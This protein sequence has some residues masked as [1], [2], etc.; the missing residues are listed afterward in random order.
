MRKIKLFYSY[1]HKDELHRDTL[2]TH[3]AVLRDQGKI[4]EWYD[5][6]ITG[7]A[8]VDEEIE[9]NMQ[10]SHIILLL[11]SP[12]FISS[13]SCRNELYRA[14][15]LKE[16]KGVE[17]VPIILRACS[18]KETEIKNLLALPRDGKP[19]TKWENGDEAWEDVC[20]QL[21]VVIE[22]VTQGITPKIKNEFKKD[23]LANP[24]TNSSLCELFVYPD[25][26]ENNVNAK[27]ENNE[28]NSEKLKCLDTF[29]HQYI[30]L[31]GKE[32]SGKTSL[33]NMLFL[34]Y[35]E[36]GFYPILINGKKISGNG[37]VLKIVNNECIQQYNNTKDYFDVVKEKR[38][39]LIDDINDQSMNKVNFTKFI[40]SI[41]DYFNTAIVFIDELSHLSDKSLKNN[42]FPYFNHYS[43]RRLGHKK[44]DELIKKCIAVDEKTEFDMLNSEQ[45]ARLDKDTKHINTIIGTNI[46]PSYP[47][48]IITI[49]HTVES[50]TSQAQNLS[51][52]SYG[53]CYQAM[54]TMQLGKV[55]VK[56]ADIDSYFN[57]LTELAYSMFDK[58]SKT[59][60]GDE[61]EEFLREYDSRF[62]TP[63]NIKR[64]LIQANIVNEKNNL[65]NFQYIYIYYY[66]VAKYIAEKINDNHVKTNFLKL[67]PNIHLK[68]SSNIII[69]IAHHTKDTD[70]LNE[71]TLSAMSA[72]EG[73][74]EAT[75]SGE[76]KNF[77]QNLSGNLT[78]LQLPDDTH[79][80]QN[81]RD[82]ILR[83]RDEL[84]DAEEEIGNEENQI[85]NP[86]LIDV[87]KA[88]KSIEILG[89]ILKNQYGS[90][91]LDELK[92]LFE[93]GQNVGLRLLKSFMELLENNEDEFKYIVRSAVEK[94]AK[95][96]NEHLG[97]EK[98][99]KLAREYIDWF[100][101]SVIHGWLNKIVDSLG[102]D[103][104][105]DI[106]DAVNDEKNTVASKLINLSIHAWH[107]KK[108]NIEKIKSIHQQLHQDNN[109]QA[110]N[111]LTNI[112]SRHLYMHHVDYRDKQRISAIFNFPVR[113]QISAQRKLEKNDQHL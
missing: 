91:E 60:P 80:V 90:L 3:L 70:F 104:L 40:S 96:R 38:I 41:K 58:N 98:I 65:Y 109:Y 19:I 67:V 29:E 26:L 71:I 6:K 102:Y 57:F 15:Q 30:L 93:E 61:F 42:S 92:K 100:S 24:I 62:I 88:A 45:L 94:I 110:I 97:N 59:I 87:R 85:K 23:L 86:V 20:N 77:I 95:E 64:K 103:K 81:E 101:R 112:V 31:E 56:A 50:I 33:C 53:H 89:Q 72:F 36:S 21:K 11:L 10:N 27:L 111:I 113:K 1:S 12:D 8:D 37:D 82:N 17:V 105:I 13:E 84:D 34:H 4:Y 66:F 79:S 46:V 76:E 18:W 49:F 69:F 108:L 7:G 28:I 48:F 63:N 43:I 83:R 44:R 32:Q 107:T 35:S 75:L 106:A 68:D 55:G 39:L 51:Q 5:R 73:F 54:I 78:K 74:P 47:V 14:L 25:I 99:N 2:K 16:E 52:T 9:S 22:K